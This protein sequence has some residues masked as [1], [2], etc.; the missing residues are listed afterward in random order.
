MHKKPSTKLLI[1]IR[2]HQ[3]SIVFWE[4]FHY[5]YNLVIE[6]KSACCQ[7]QIWKWEAIWLYFSQIVYFLLGIV[8]PGIDECCLWENLTLCTP[9][10]DPKATAKYFD[11]IEGGIYT[12]GKFFRVARK[13]NLFMF[14]YQGTISIENYTWVLKRNVWTKI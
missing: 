10:F 6:K 1:R 12:N 13:L 14:L 3:L 5:G 2:L 7:N 9:V 4:T 11:P 8:L